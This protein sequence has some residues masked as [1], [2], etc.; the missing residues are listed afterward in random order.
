MSEPTSVHEG[1]VPLS[2]ARRVN[3][4]C[5][6]FE[7]AWKAGP[8]P[9]IEDYRDEVPASD[10][11][12][13]VRELVA[14]DIDYR[15]QAGEEPT[16]QDYAS[17]FPNLTLAPLLAVPA[18]EQARLGADLPTVPGYELL[19]ELGRGGMG[20]VYEARQT[21]LN[22]PVA[23]KMILAGAHAGPEELAR[24]HNEAE[25]VARLQHPHI[26]QVYDVGQ[27]D[28][29]PYLALEYVDGP[30]LAQ[31]LTGTPLPVRQAARLV[32]LLAQAVHVAHQKGVIHRDLTPGN[33]LLA[34][35][36]PAQ[37]VRFGGVEEAVYYHPKVA[38]F[39]LAKVLAGGGP[40]LTQSGAI[41][42]T[43]SYMAPEQA[44]GRA[45]AVGPA[46]DVYALGAILY[47]L[48]TGRPPF[49]AETPLETL[50]QV[51]AV[52]P[53]PPSRLQPKLPRDLTTICLKC[54]A[55]EPGKR[56]A[57]AD[58]L[59]EDLRRFQ[60]GEPIRARPVGRGERLGRWCRRNPALAAV[61]GLALVA[62]VATVV[63]SI[64]FAIHQG[65]AADD[66]GQAAQ[67]LRLALRDAETERDRTAT[68]L[69]EHCL[70]QGLVAC[71]KDQDTALGLLWMSRALENTPARNVD[72]QTLIR[73][74]LAGWQTEVPALKGIFP[75][76]GMVLAAAF[77]PDGQ[78]V[79]TGSYQE[80][81][82][83]SA[84]TG[85]ELTPPLRHQGWVTGVA[86]SPDG[87]A[88]LTGSQDGTARLWSA[89]TGKELARPLRHQGWVVA[90]AFSPDGK[91]VVSGS[92][93]VSKGTGEARL[94]SAATGKELTPP[95]RHQSWVNAVAFSPDSRTVLT[96][97]GTE[98][99]LWSVA[100]GKELA[101][102]LRHQ[103]QVTAVAFSPD[104]R[105]V[106]TGGGT[107]ARLW[108]AA[109]GKELTPPMRHQDVVR[110]M[111]FSPNRLRWL[112]LGTRLPPVLRDE[113]VV[114][115]V[116]FSPDGRTVLTASGSA[117]RLW[118]AATGQEL[119]PPMRHQDWV[120]AVAFSPDGQTV[121]TG[122]KDNVA[123]L[124]SAATGQEL[125]PPL[126]HQDVVRTVAFS[127]DGKAVLTGSWNVELKKGEARLW[128]A[129]TGQELI[130]PLRHQ[131]PVLRVA[132][133]P[134]GRTVLTASD[135]AAR[136]WAAATGKE[137]APPMRHQD[138]VNA[139]AFS[140]D[141]K[142]VLTGSRD[143][144]ARLWAAATGKELTPPLRHQ[145]EVNAVAFSPDG[146]AVLTGSYD[147]TARLW[148]AATGKELT[149]PLRHQHQVTAVAFSP[150][151]KAV[152][153]GCY[154]K[155][156]RLWQRPVAVTGDVERI[157]VWTQVLTGKEIDDHGDLRVLDTQTWQERR[158]Q[159]IELGGSPIPHA[160]DG[161]VWHQLNASEAESAG[162]WFAAAWHLGRL[163][164]ASRGQDGS[165][166]ARRGSANIQL[167]RWLEAARD[168]GRA[169]EL[170]PNDWRV[171]SLLGRSQGN[172]GQ[173]EQAVANYSKAIRLKSDV[174]WCWEERGRFNAVL[175]RWE[176]AAR[177]YS[178]AIE[179]DPGQWEW[180]QRTAVLELAARQT[181]SYQQTCT[182]MVQRFANSK[183]PNSIYIVA[184]PCVL[185]PN[186][187]ADLS[188]VVGLAE[189][190]VKAQPNNT[191]ALKNLGRLL[192]RAGRYQEAIQR[193]HES[194]TK[195]PT[196]KASAIDWLFL[197]MAHQKLGHTEEGKSCLAKAGE[198]RKAK[199]IAWPQRLEFR[200]L[201]REAERLVQGTK[202]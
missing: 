26:V 134:D 58:E 184:W 62:A 22:R 116:A 35:A 83:W 65:R 195:R 176:A 79:L 131:G 124:W 170:Q 128:A 146:K 169:S 167:G 72:L 115:A 142:A 100:T 154:D 138:W 92:G 157:T 59:A 75:H 191:D 55:K 181:K 106:L 37:G 153:T 165:L 14:L 48:L 105:T 186:A 148:S 57:S 90:V 97:G 4:V 152:L 27:A 158:K 47:E 156:V 32:E 42:G 77:S 41:V 200:I 12:T 185:A 1:T 29:C 121:L 10:R 140:P 17:R 110:T 178:K 19:R 119:A 51:Q 150:D 36:D 7:L 177:D 104:G 103:H 56:Y 2:A 44:A 91:M 98:A 137:L 118:A 166:L 84:A 107:E 120:N 6:R 143:G 89:A 155:T 160:E 133:S 113:D 86:F 15:R 190:A 174:P 187:V 85:Q 66:L 25:A 30:S 183:D 18:A 172:L 129:A 53:V 168:F 49:K 198:F 173:Y 175:E 46:A 188:P 99:R 3:A 136:L 162:Q 202:H 96:G 39:G 123:R 192:Y 114:R 126:R 50:L 101:P 38:D 67:D 82:L 87:K 76:Q 102:P 109:T 74:R 151:G 182:A 24:F 64:S 161:R 31:R 197:A 45:K 52:E 23:L 68:R 8:R 111:A 125:I 40:T 33:V 28:G 61:S 196:K 159:L 43:P 180:W 73:T 63:V 147:Q 78:A 5:N 144:T 11:S 88:L 69:A 163:I 189:K 112:A 95:L 141:G 122:C 164:Q 71:A 21:G 34:R 60:A 94:W 108:S 132:F 16:A 199:G 139:V 194:I 135:S 130:P 54:L 9:C 127:P 117:A 171:W 145:G 201:H 13:L 179:L 20:V 93:D 80:A 149:P 70:D 193:V 81:R